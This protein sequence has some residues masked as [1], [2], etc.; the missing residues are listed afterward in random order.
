MKHRPK[1]PGFFKRFKGRLT[2]KLIDM[3]GGYF[4]PW[5]WGWD[6]MT[7]NCVKCKKELG[8]PGETTWEYVFDSCDTCYDCVKKSLI[9]R[10]LMRPLFGGS[11]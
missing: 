2:G 5:D 9:E 1:D 3:G 4:S 6:R 7:E 10:G 11:R 8:F